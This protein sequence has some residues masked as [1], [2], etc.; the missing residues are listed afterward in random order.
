MCKLVPYWGLSPQPGSTY[1]LQKLNHNVFGIVNHATTKSAVYLCDERYGPKN[2]D[3]TISYVTHYLGGLSTFVRRLHL[4]LDNTS[5]TNKNWYT[6]ALEMVQQG[7]MDFI[8]VSFLI[9]GHT[10]FT[11]DQLFAR[12]AQT[13][14]RS[15]VFTTEELQAVISQ[16]ADVVVE[17][18][19]VVC[20]WRTTLLKYTKLPGIRSLHDF[21]IMKNSA[22]GKVVCKVRKLCNCGPFTNASIGIQKGRT[23][24]EIAIPNE[25]D[26]YLNKGKTRELPAMKQDHLRQMY[27]SFIPR[28]HCLPFM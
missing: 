6:M 5:S 14:N 3:H 15:D 8:R 22:T 16:H 24:E 10:K 13:Y 19:T 7:R 21:I 27:R 28:D 25:E 11:P 9:A 23:V 17:D 4:F 12:I 2:T 26:T 18:G 1:Y 20:D